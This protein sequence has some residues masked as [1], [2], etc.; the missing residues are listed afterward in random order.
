MKTRTLLTMTVLIFVVNVFGQQLVDLTFTA[1]DN[2]AYIQLDSIK[3]INRTQGGETMIYWPDTTLSIEITLGD[4]LLYIGYSTGFP[5]GIQE[6]NQEISPFQLFQNYPNP[7]KGQSIIS[8]YLP[9]NGT[10]NI[11]VNDIQGRVIITNNQYMDKGIHSFCFSLGNNSF[12]FLTARWKGMTQSIKIINAEPCTGNRC[13]LDYA[14][15]GNHEYPVKSS[16]LK[17]NLVMKESGILDT[18]SAN[19][20]YTFQFATNIP[21]PG[22]PSVEY[23]G[24]VYNT[25]QI[26]SQCWLKENLNIGIMIDSNFNQT[27]NGILEKYCYR[28]EPDSCTKYGGLYQWKEMMQYTNQQGVQGICPPDWHIPTD[29]EWMVLEGAVDS[30]YGIEDNVWF[31]IAT[32]RGYDA[33]TN[34]KSTSGWSHEGNGTDLFGFSGLP[35][36]IRV[37]LGYFD[38][39]SSDEWWW[40]SNNFIGTSAISRGL[41]CLNEGVFRHQDLFY[42]G[43]GFSVR[44]VKN[45]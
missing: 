9:E 25:V 16:L 38:Y 42:E 13:R 4:L 26:F 23:G 2:A 45:Y 31:N 14:G 10:V 41:N 44:C 11:I 21:C 43:S 18:P 27:N 33:G 20:T 29:Q 28:N 1:I 17:N 6:V 12:Y 22:T 37:Y 36:G 34:L 39:N 32:V 8:I 19:K 30:Q 35:G 3:V 40:S 7:V 24:Q 15:S 5:M